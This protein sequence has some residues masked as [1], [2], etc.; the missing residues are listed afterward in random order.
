M[1]VRAFDETGT[2]T[3]EQITVN[4]TT[5]GVQGNPRV[6]VGADGKVL[7]VW[8]A[9]DFFDPGPSEVR[10]SLI[11]LAANQPVGDVTFLLDAQTGVQENAS[12][13]TGVGVQAIALD[14]DAANSVTFSLTSNPGGMFRINETTGRIEVG[15]SIDR[16][17]IPSGEVTVEVTAT[18]SDGSTTSASR[19]IQI[20]TSKS[21]PPRRPSMPTRPRTRSRRMRAPARSSGSP[22]AR[23]TRMR[24]QTR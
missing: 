3:S 23:P 21:S 20:L 10:A 11:S 6:A 17:A 4:A 18:S 9:D 8:A 14:P 15:G 7:V 1:I 22:Q 16:E 5:A 13:G 12:V 19:T 24:R 2:P